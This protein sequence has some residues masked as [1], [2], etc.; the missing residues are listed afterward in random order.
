M[1]NKENFVIEKKPKNPLRKQ[2]T[3]VLLSK[4]AA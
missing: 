3:G 4:Y 2:K 1:A